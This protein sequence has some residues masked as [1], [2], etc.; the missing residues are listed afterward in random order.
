M[1]RWTIYALLVIPAV[2][3]G[4][5]SRF[6]RAQPDNALTADEPRQVADAIDAFLRGVGRGD[7]NRALE[8]LLQTSP[9]RNSRKI[10][11][12][13]GAI[14]RELPRCGAYLGIEPLRVERFGRSMVH[15]LYLYRCQDFPVVWRFTFYRAEGSSD[16]SLISLK[17]DMDYDQISREN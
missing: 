6:G 2:I 1:K 7:A 16:W 17:F 3:W 12:L 4:G 11:D 8:E 10:T 14:R 9:L 5:M 15:C 13:G